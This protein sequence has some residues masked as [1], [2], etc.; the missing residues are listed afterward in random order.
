ME[1]DELEGWVDEAVMSFVVDM[2]YKLRLNNHKGHWKELTFKDLFRKLEAEV[3]E[4]RDALCAL[5]PDRNKKALIA[6]IHE[7][8]DVSNYAMMMADNAKRMINEH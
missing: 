4:L 8:S 6:F 7:C 5:T 1:R 2:K 3:T